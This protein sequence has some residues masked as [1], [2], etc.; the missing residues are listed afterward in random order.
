MLQREVPPRLKHA[1]RRRRAGRRNRFIQSRPRRSRCCANSEERHI[2]IRYGDAGHSYET[3]FGDYLIGAKKVVVE[4]PYIRMRHQIAN[5]VRLCE[6]L[7]R[8]G[9]VRKISLVTGSDGSDQKAE[10]A[11][12]LSEL[13]RA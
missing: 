7:V 4:D 8:Q 12:S 3:L 6:L 13:A 1:E 10:I 9:T 2:T 11:E 5:F